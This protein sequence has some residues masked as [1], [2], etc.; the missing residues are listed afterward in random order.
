MEISKRGPTPLD[1]PWK[2]AAQY[3]ATEPG[4]QEL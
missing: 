3:E 1:L 4:D 2:D